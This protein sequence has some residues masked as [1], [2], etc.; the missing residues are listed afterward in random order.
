MKVVLRSI[1]DTDN[2]VALSYLICVDCIKG[3][4]PEYP[5]KNLTPWGLDSVVRGTTC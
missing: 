2:L 5:A 1:M 4:K 3:G